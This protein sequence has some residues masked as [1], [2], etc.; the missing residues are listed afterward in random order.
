MKKVLALFFVLFF[1]STVCFAQDIKSVEEGK[2]PPK[3]QNEGKWSKAVSELRCK[4]STDKKVYK[5]GEQMLLTLSWQNL[6]NKEI[7]IYYREDQIPYN[8][9]SFKREDGSIPLGR[10]LMIEAAPQHFPVIVAGD[11]YSISLKAK[12]LKENLKETWILTHQQQAGNLILKF[13]GSLLGE[14]PVLLDKP[15]TFF[16]S[17]SYVIP[18]DAYLVR[19]NP[20]AWAGEIE[21]G[22]V[23]FEVVGAQE[24]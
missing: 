12:I 5:I 13:E 20:N 16:V 11:T 6:S 4:V 18:A 19:N 1:G 2:Q 23:S 14:F 3:S 9:L 24:R 21:S 8:L 17:L 15:G 22:E 7:Q 10:L